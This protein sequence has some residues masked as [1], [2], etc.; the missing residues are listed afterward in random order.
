MIARERRDVFYPKADLAT[1]P[2]A[3]LAGAE[4][5][6]PYLFPICRS[7][8]GDDLVH[9]AA[10]T[11][12]FTWHRVYRLHLAS[13]REVIARMSAASPHTVDL[14]LCLD[15]W[16]SHTLRAAGLPA[17]EVFAVDLSRQLCPWDYALMEPARGV[18]LRE[19]D[20]D[21]Q[22]LAPYL[23]RVGAF[24]AQLHRVEVEGFGLLDVDPA[25]KRA[26][27][28]CDSWAD[29]LGNHLERHLDVC[30]HIGAITGEES[31][32]IRRM[33][34][35]RAAWLVEVKPKLMHGDPGNHNVF[36]ADGEVTAL[37]DWEDA[38]AGDPAYEVAFWATFHP[39]RRHPAFF[40]GYFGGGRP[41]E[42]FM[43]RF[44]FYFLR[45]AL[46]KTVVR[47]NL[48][49]KDLPGRPPAS[50]RIRRAVQALAPLAA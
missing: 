49:L 25:G 32:V 17:L 14:P 24:L 11:G 47:H 6:L 48:A 40:E 5:I 22:A 28:S 31:V 15:R 43:E 21:D 35:E 29:Y 4:E 20:G 33:F 46:A 12:P 1:L 7:Q 16:A 23:T 10:L 36:V 30:R 42:D 38:L 41:D 26:R 34:A 37:I 19:L 45:V 27:G 50:L 44:W 3:P 9:A 18:C 13:G 39:E 8:L 2:G